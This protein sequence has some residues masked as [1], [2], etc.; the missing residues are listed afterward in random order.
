MT[1]NP[2]TFTS[3]TTNHG[4]ASAVESAAAGLGALVWWSLT[5]TRIAPSKLRAIFASEGKD[6]A[7]VPDIDQSAAIRRA[8]REW[9][10]GRGK[11]DRFRAEV[12]SEVAG[13]M[14]IGI[15]RREQVNATEVGWVQVDS[16]EF[17]AT[18]GLWTA[19]GS[20]PE[21]VA[22]AGYADEIRTT[23]D[24]Q[25]IRPN[26]LQKGLAE[27]QSVCLRDRGGVYFVPAAF[28]PEL[29]RLGR[30]VSA[31]GKCHLDIVHAQATPASRQSI[32]GGASATMRDEIGALVERIKGW[33]ESARRVSES[34]AATVLGELAELKMRADLYA[35]A[36]NVSLDDISDA[37]A[38]AKVEA[39]RIISGGVA[40]AP[41]PARKIDPDAT[42]IDALGAAVAES[43]TD[44]T[45][46]VWIEVETARKHGL[47][48]E[49]YHYWR[50]GVGGAS[51]A[52]FGIGYAARIRKSG[53][54]VIAIS[55]A[56]LATP[57]SDEPGTKAQEPATTAEPESAAD[58]STTGDA[59]PTI[60]AL[61]IGDGEP[62][63]SEPESGEP[64]SVLVLD[65]EEGIADLR[66]TLAQKTKAEV[67]T[68]FE[69]TFGASPGSRSK[70]RMIEELIPRLA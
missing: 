42:V 21:S 27:A 14:T 50:F 45:G 58:E 26:V 67:A 54:D 60:G 18:S 7:L 38:E 56:P 57:P 30:I 65:S 23:L 35:D 52:A 53:A 9:S 49:S 47:N 37:I 70:G 55:L 13:S 64:E 17:D 15:L 48:V 36:L 66:E 68:V 20:R 28:E 19:I 25:W 62:E 32:A 63:S 3:T 34:S 69:K 44:L 12:A 11:A 43:N 31:I 59:W 29:L 6:P 46:R 5:D 39:E 2:T 1:T 51:A 40:A 33:N 24:H 41:A 22:F 16:C 10:V 61:A 8:V 4:A